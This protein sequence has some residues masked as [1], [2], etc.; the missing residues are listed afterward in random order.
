MRTCSILYGYPHKTTDFIRNAISQDS[1]CDTKGTYGRIAYVRCNIAELM[2]MARCFP[3]LETRTFLRTMI[4]GAGMLAVLLVLAC[5]TW[6]VDDDGGA[7]SA[8]IQTAE[9]AA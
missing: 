9:A 7:D 6:V 1:L 4:F 2:V 8:G 3:P 5:T